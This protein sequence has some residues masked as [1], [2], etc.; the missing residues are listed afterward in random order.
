MKELS[1]E[2]NLPGLQKLKHD[3]VYGG[4]RAEKKGNF[5]KFDLALKEA[6]DFLDAHGADFGTDEV[7]KVKNKMA[8]ATRSVDRERK[9]FNRSKPRG[10]GF[11]RPWN[12]NQL[13]AWAGMFCTVLVFYVMVALLASDE[14][15]P[16]NYLIYTQ[17]GLL[18]VQLLLWVYLE[19][20]VVFA[21]MGLGGGGGGGGGGARSKAKKGEGVRGERKRRQYP[22]STLTQLMNTTSGCCILG[23]VCADARRP[24]RR[25]QGFIF[26][27]IDAGLHPPRTNELT[28][29][30]ATQRDATRRDAT[31]QS[32]VV[33]NIKRGHCKMDEINGI[34]GSLVPTYVAPPVRFVEGPG[35]LA[36]RPL[37]YEKR[38]TDIVEDAA[39]SSPI[40][41][42]SDDAMSYGLSVAMILDGGKA[43]EAEAIKWRNVHVEELYWGRN[44]KFHPM[45]ELTLTK[46]E[47]KAE[48]LPAKVAARM[49]VSSVVLHPGQVLDTWVKGWGE[50]GSLCGK[51]RVQISFV[52]RASVSESLGDGLSSADS[53]FT[54]SQIQA[55][56]D[57]WLNLAAA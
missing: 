46:K 33:Q 51:L 15:A 25:G 24:L 23:A 40:A 8:K 53:Y 37:R 13:S 52:P 41:K 2:V 39:A 9:I 11:D 7:A 21:G 44:T 35:T 10:C 17:G 50:D 34:P 3:I 30:N 43:E 55:S 27:S 42:K 47:G 19:R 18:V 14:S 1:D 31:Q 38:D 28:K 32:K 12:E 20:L 57:S 49:Q 6:N 5:E 45:V 16:F 48:D 26:E 56:S 4:S 54:P 29:R 22:R 36:I